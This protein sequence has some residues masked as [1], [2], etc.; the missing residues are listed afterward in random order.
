[1]DEKKERRIAIVGTAPTWRSLPWDDPT[2]EVWALNDMHVLDLPRAD[3]WYDLHPLD[4]MFFRPADRKTFAGEVPAGFY[5]RP[6]NHLQWLR[7]Q[8]I[9]VFVQDAAAL[10]SPNARTFPRA[11]I[12]AKFGRSFASSPAWMIAH[13][14]YEGVTELHVYG[15]HL[16][17]EWEYQKQKPNMTFLLGLAAGLGVKVVLPKGCPLL[18]E[19]HQY[20]YEEDPDT[21]KVELKRRV[22]RLQEEIAVLDKREKQRKWYRRRDPNYASRK[23]LLQAQILDCQ[24][25]IQHVQAGRVPVGF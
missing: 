15:I 8:T 2:L 18:H 13:A 19:S 6:T 5:V 4:R 21:P 20:A 22:L 7:K 9:P 11:E 10:G 16:A 1:M 3:R 14:L 17:T 12:E 24:F 23:E 25:G